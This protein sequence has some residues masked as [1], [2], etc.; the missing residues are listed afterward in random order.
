MRAALLGPPPH[1]RHPGRG[2]IHQP[3]QLADQP[4]MVACG[5]LQQRGPVRAM[6]GSS[7]IPT[8]PVGPSVAIAI[9]I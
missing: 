2:F 5:G 4:D 1:P 7:N 3:R 6:S 9:A 8:T